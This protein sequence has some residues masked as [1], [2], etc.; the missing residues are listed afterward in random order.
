M[1]SFSTIICDYVQ[2]RNQ[3]DDELD[4]NADR[5]CLL[6]ARVV[7]VSLIKVFGDDKALLVLCYYH[8][9]P[10]INLPSAI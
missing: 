9:I 8:E 4:V 6:K 7:T 2:S 5:Y 3:Q 1:A 10:S